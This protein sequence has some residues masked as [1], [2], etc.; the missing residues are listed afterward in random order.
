MSHG[1]MALG[2]TAV[3]LAG[4]VWYLPA[5][6]DLR[7][8]QDR[9]R[10][11]RA[12]AAGVLTGW[13][14]AALAALLLLT[15]VP[16]TA[17]AVVAATGAAAVGSLGVVGRLRRVRERRETAAFTAALAPGRGP[18]PHRVRG[19]RPKPARNRAPAD[20]AERDH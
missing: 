15:P 19:P 18:S 12:A 13:G 11:R 7:A 5:Y 10:S 2:V 1:V 14:S 8:G 3:C 6:V 4:N 17:V 16:L 9:P 20:P